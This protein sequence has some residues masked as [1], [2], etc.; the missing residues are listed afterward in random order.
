MVYIS[1]TRSERVVE[2]FDFFPH[3]GPITISI[4]Q[5]IGNPGGKTINTRLTKSNTDWTILSGR[6][7]TNAR[8]PTIG[9]DIQGCTTG[10][11]KGYDVSPM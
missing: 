7:Q 5:G 8:S 1:K 2:T 6:R 4:I 10:T 11:K 3:R 9:S